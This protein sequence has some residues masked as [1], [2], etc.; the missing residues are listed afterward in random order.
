MSSSKLVPGSEKVTTACV[1][2]SCSK[3]ASRSLGVEPI[4]ESP[5]MP[6]AVLTPNPAR[7]TR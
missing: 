3:S 5:P 6:I 7:F 1:S 4:K 2:E